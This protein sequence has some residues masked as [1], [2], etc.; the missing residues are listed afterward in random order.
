MAK[1]VTFAQEGGRGRDNGT[2]PMSRR[3]IQ[4]SFNVP[5]VEYADESPFLIFSLHS[6]RARG[7]S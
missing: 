6:F 3:S 5:D 4:S 2:L 7:H 1:N